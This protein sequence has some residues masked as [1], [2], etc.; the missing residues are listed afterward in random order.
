MCSIVCESWR[1]NKNNKTATVNSLLQAFN[2]YVWNS[3]LCPGHK[4]NPHCLL[5]LGSKAPLPKVTQF[6]VVASVLICFS[7]MHKHLLFLLR[8][9]DCLKDTGK[10]GRK[11]SMASS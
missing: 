2:F 11:S 9:W 6:S 10:K 3:G 1:T 4:I 7:S 5:D 8:S